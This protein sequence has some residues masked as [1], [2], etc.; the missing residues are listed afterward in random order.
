VDKPTP[1]RHPSVRIDA[2]ATVAVMVNPSA[3]GDDQHTLPERVATHE[4]SPDVD[5]DGALRRLVDRGASV[6]GVVGGDGS[7]GCAA[8]VACDCGVA[9]WPVPGGTLNHFSRA[10][11]VETVD[12]AIRALEGGHVRRVDLGDAGGVPFINNASIGMYGD[13]VRHRERLEERLPIGKWA[14]AALA[15]VRTIARARTVRLEI[16]GRPERVFMVFIGNN[17]YDGIGQGARERLDEGL[18]DVVVLRAPTRLPRLTLMGL[19]AIGR[20]TRSRFVRRASASQVLVVTAESTSL[21]FDG[22]ARPVSGEVVFRSRAGALNVV[23]PP[24]A[25]P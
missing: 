18:L 11:G 2:T 6:I 17:R 10:L 15:G 19:A 7:T 23:A 5:L 12:D 13:L 4:M 1:E 14:C 8:G 24:A 16:D 9:L 20:L 3:G 25:S 22:E 21:A